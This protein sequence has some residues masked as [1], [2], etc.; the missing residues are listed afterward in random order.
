GINIAPI[1]LIEGWQDMYRDM[2]DTME[3]LL[4]PQ[5]KR[6][7]FFE[8]IF[9]TYGYAHQKINPAAFPNAIDVFNP[10]LMRP[11]GRGKLCY[12]MEA[13]QPAIDFLKSE[14]SARF[15]ES[16]ISYII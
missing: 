13:R 9:M 11:K 5:L 4:D 10:D 6:R 8:I 14:I 1:I 12:T 7:T 16:T 15:P 2:F 3:K